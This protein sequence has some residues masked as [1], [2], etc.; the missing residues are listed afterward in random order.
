[1]P[2]KPRKPC[3]HPG[4]PALTTSRYCP[5]HTKAEARR[6]EQQQRDPATARHYGRSWQAVRTAYLSAHPLCEMCLDAGRCVPA[7]LF[8]RLRLTA[9]P[10]PGWWITWGHI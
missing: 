6:Y 2:Y 4:C 3:A 5:A 7:V 1:M 10:S 8:P 9:A